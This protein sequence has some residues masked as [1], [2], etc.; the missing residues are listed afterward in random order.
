MRLIVAELG[1]YSHFVSREFSYI[2]RELIEA[3]GW[4]HVEPSVLRGGS[5]RDQLARRCG[6]FPEVILF[7][8]GEWFLCEHHRQLEKLPAAKWF[9]ADDLH[10]HDARELRE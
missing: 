7:W 10:H 3:Y 9:V 2:I 8:G 4:R 6:E 5:M 1:A